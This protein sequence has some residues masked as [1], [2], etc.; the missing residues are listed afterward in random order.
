MYIWLARECLS[1]LGLLKAVAPWQ[2][3]WISCQNLFCMISH[4]CSRYTVSVLVVSKVMS[5][6]DK[7]F[8]NIIFICNGMHT[9]HLQFMHF[10][11]LL[12]TFTI[13]TFIWDGVEVMHWW[14]QLLS[15]D[16]F[17]VLRNLISC[18]LISSMSL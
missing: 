18:C 7:S 8:C 3:F 13:I 4:K 16:V 15:Y 10:V 1:F 6:L 12:I 2:Q 17:V 9:L 11:T 5:I 14:M